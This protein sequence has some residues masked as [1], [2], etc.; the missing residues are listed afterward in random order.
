MLKTPLIRNILMIFWI[1][2]FLASNI[3]QATPKWCDPNTEEF[4]FRH[5]AQL[6]TIPNDPMNNVWVQNV[7]YMADIN[8]NPDTTEYQTVVQF[9]YLQRQYYVES[10]C[11][12][13]YEHIEP[14]GENT[15]CVTT[16]KSEVNRPQRLVPGRNGPPV[17][18]RAMYNVIPPEVPR[19]EQLAALY[20]IFES[21]AISSNSMITV[22]NDP[23][24][25]K[26][27]F[28]EIITN[29]V[30]KET[31][32][33]DLIFFD[34]AGKIKGHF[35]SKVVAINSLSAGEQS[36]FAAIDNGN[37]T[38]VQ[39]PLGPV[40]YTVPGHVYLSSVVETQPNSYLTRKM[41]PMYQMTTKMIKSGRIDLNKHL[42][43]K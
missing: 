31:R 29:K 43:R 28:T 23:Q 42:K 1:P 18:P 19:Y 41:T 5:A 8:P 9:S 39:D 34:P 22:A 11:A 24:F 26:V 37:L 20:L 10:E 6:G 35:D 15:W 30:S 17:E 40:G 12:F 16:W 4:K 7:T 21:N 27:G 33:Y 25:D 13:F 2:V 14:C 32:D 3:A 36:V 38:Q